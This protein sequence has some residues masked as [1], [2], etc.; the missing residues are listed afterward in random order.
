MGY[1]RIVLYRGC[2][3]SSVGASTAPPLPWPAGKLIVPPGVYSFDNGENVDM[4][5]EGFYALWADNGATFDGGNLI[6]Y[7]NDVLTLMSSLARVCGYGVSD[8]A[9]TIPQQIA[10]ARARVL[11]L[12]C[13]PTISFVEY[14]CLQFGIPFREV[15]FLT[16][17]TLATP[18]LDPTLDPYNDLIDNGH[19]LLE[20]RINNAWVLVDV[21]TN[22]AFQDAAGNWLSAQ[23]V[24]AAGLANCT[25]VSIA[26]YDIEQQNW[27]GNFMP[28]TEANIRGRP[29]NIDRWRRG[30]YQIPGILSA[31]GN[32]YFYLPDGVSTTAAWVASVSPNYKLLPKDQ[33]NA[34]FY[35]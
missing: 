6:V 34:K 23:Q 10:I 31:D 7:Q 3:L 9:L 12:R 27:S 30:I 35:S 33:W 1:N 19:V 20:V 28:N 8:E 29:E 13:G 2:V 15:H 14:W 5:R 26:D 32:V 22:A 18:G 4:T 21:A 11:W 16:G 25:T 17:N 24:I